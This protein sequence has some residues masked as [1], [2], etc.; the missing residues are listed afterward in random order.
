MQTFGTE[1]DSEGS[2]KIEEAILLFLAQNIKKSKVRAAK[3]HGKEFRSRLSV[4]LEGSSIDCVTRSVKE[5]HRLL[6]NLKDSQPSILASVP[7]VYEFL[8]D[9]SNIKTCSPSAEQFL[10]HLVASLVLFPNRLQRA[11]HV[12]FCDSWNPRLDQLV[13]NLAQ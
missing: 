7:L 8:R 10:F 1:I 11:Y 13:S 4:L 5:K 9:V 2:A 3:N 6:L 12:N